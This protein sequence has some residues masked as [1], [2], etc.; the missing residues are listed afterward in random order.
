MI[1]EYHVYL[2]LLKKVEFSIFLFLLYPP[3]LFYFAFQARTLVRPSV[4]LSVRPS[5]CLFVCP[6]RLSGCMHSMTL[7]IGGGQGHTTHTR[8]TDRAVAPSLQKGVGTVRTYSYVFLASV[9][10]ATVFY[11][12][13]VCLYFVQQSY[14]SKVRIFLRLL[15]PVA[16]MQR[17]IARGRKGEGEN[18]QPI[19]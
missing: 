8:Q 16:C 14:A 5:V 10:L 1:Q 17:S 11:Y 3:L 6:T 19:Y 15:L 12:V 13:S 18:S 2:V 7:S 4:S 9:C